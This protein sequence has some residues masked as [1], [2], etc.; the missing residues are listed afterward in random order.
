VLT[1]PKAAFIPA[2]LVTAAL[3]T[4]AVAAAATSG[5]DGTTAAAPTTAAPIAPTTSVTPTPAAED[6][7]ATIV[8]FAF[9]PDP[10]TVAVGQSVTWTNDDPFA[11]TVKAEDGT[12]D[13]G[14]L[15][16]G[17]AFTTTFTTP[18]TYAYLCGIH[19]SMTG[20]VVVGP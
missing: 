4:F 10:I 3:A 13:S 5:D 18:G 15:A 14:R 16:Q 1:L 9:S 12:F 2:A 8:D 19:N 17:A 11:H 20:T 6:I 7:A